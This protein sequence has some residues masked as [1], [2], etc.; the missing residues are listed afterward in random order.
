MKTPPLPTHLTQSLSLSFS[1]SVTEPV[2]QVDFPAVTICS[3]G[4]FSLTIFQS[5]QHQVSTNNA[6]GLNRLINLGLH[7]KAV[8]K[9]L[10][11]D[12]EAWSLNTKIKDEG[13]RQ[14]RDTKMDPGQIAAFMKQKFLVEEDQSIFDILAAMATTGDVDSVIRNNGIR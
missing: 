4:N 6:T 8:E 2:T 13:A 1:H 12:L 7:M 10:M 3:P 9:A 14:K 5:L 11:K